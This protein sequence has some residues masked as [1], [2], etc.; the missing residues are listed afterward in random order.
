MIFS[1][2]NHTKKL[3]ENINKAYD[4]SLPFLSQHHF[5]MEIVSA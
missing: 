5:Q 1:S 3:I 4:Y 2:I